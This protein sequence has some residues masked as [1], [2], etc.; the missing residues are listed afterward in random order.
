[1]NNTTINAKAL[2]MPSPMYNTPTIIYLNGLYSVAKII[3]FL[4]YKE[5]TETG[6][7]DN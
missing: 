4:F 2:P 7:Y 3:T 6:K 5:L 1:M